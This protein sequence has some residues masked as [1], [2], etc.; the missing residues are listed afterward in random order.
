MLTDA[1]YGVFTL[2]VPKDWDQWFLTFD[3]DAVAITAERQDAFWGETFRDSLSAANAL[4]FEGTAMHRAAFVDPGSDELN[5]VTVTLSES[6]GI[7]AADLEATLVESFEP[8]S[9]I[10]SVAAYPLDVGLLVEITL[11]LDSA[12]VGWSDDLVEFK[13]FVLDE[14]NGQLWGI[15]C[16]VHESIAAE[17]ESL[18]L[19]IRRSFV[20]WGPVIPDA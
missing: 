9:E 11:R 8:F 14:V 6:S 2:T 20:P 4:A 5:I 13:S 18:C 16:N 15:T 7:A 3:P 19:E 17:A 12:Q 10:V 1:G